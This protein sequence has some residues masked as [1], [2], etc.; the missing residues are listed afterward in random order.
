MEKQDFIKTLQIVRSNSPQRKFT[1]SVDIIINLKNLNIKKDEE[2]INNFVTLPFTRG[3]KVR[4][5]A[6]VGNEL[7]TKAKAADKIVHVDEFKSLDKKAIKKLAAETDF[8]IAQANIMPLIAGTFGKT[9]GPRG[10]MPNPKAGS[11]IQ[12][13]GE[14]KPIVEKLQKTVKLE[15]KNEPV[16]K[17]VIGVESMKD[18]EIAENGAA[19]IHSLLQML[20]QE[21]QNLDTIFIKFTMSPPYQV[22]GKVQPIKTEVKTEVKQDMKSDKKEVKQEEKKKPGKEKKE[23]PAKKP[24]EKKK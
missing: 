11:V 18:E 14:I 6:L 23:K 16:I 19:L 13:T 20:P 3:K 4:V 7:A 9:L 21:K 22:G 5:T 8:F 15:T 1:Q 17:T 24:K 12:P 2:K 10:L